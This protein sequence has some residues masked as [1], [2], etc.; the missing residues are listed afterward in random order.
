MIEA[1]ALVAVAL[2]VAVPLLVVLG[3]LAHPDWSQPLRLMRLQAEEAATRM[4]QLR[5]EINASIKTA[6]DSIAKSVGGLSNVT[7][8]EMLVTELITLTETSRVS[9]RE[10]REEVAAS[11]KALTESVGGSMKEIAEAQGNQLAVFGRELLV[12]AQT[13]ERKLDAVREVVETRL[14]AL[15]EASNSGKALHPR[16]SAT[17]SAQGA[18]EEIASVRNFNDSIDSIAKSMEGVAAFQ[19]RQF[20]GFAKQ[21]RT[22]MES[23][24]RKLD[25]LR[26]VVEER[27]QRLQEGTAIKVDE[28]QQGVDANLRRTLE[29]GLRESFRPV[30]HRLEQIHEGLGELHTLATGVGDGQQTSSNAKQRGSRDEVQLG[31]LLE[32]VLTADQ[33]D[34]NVAIRDGSSERIGFAIKLPRRDEDGEDLVWLPI[35]ARCPREDYHRLLDAEETAD[36]RAVAVAGGDLE[37]AIKTAARTM[38][39]QYLNPPKTTDFAIMFLPAEELFAEV[40]RRPGLAEYVQREYHVVVAGPTTLAALLQSLQWGSRA[41]AIQEPPSAGWSILAAITRE[42]GTFGDILGGVRRGLMLASDTID[43][44]VRKRR[45]NG[46]LSGVQELSAA[47]AESLLTGS[48]NLAPEVAA[49]RESHGHG[50]A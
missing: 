17:G 28:M 44:I 32:Q 42:G 2:T 46:T 30:N 45:T 10:L 41:L 40:I 11:S 6:G 16:E 20:D 37:A 19:Q 43:A 4:R 3:R 35:D 39:E 27:L 7:K 48:E 49:Q 24:E 47:D 1:L 31:N 9:A 18:R 26:G 25:A 14:N 5:E 12:L 8:P 38:S 13:T 50:D 23:N 34:Q 21:L 36:A 29:T 22:L 33:F 15:S